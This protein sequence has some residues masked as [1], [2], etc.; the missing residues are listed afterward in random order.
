MRANDVF[1]LQEA[2]QGY[3]L[4]GG[5]RGVGGEEDGEGSRGVREDPEYHSKSLDGF[6][7]TCQPTAFMRKE[8]AIKYRLKC[9]FIFLKVEE[10]SL[11]VFEIIPDT[12]AECVSSFVKSGTELRRGAA[13]HPSHPEQAVPSNI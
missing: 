8:N 4:Y 3:L 10:F 11:L 1:E 13:D 9:S 2:M 6:L 7:K 5:V 12:Q